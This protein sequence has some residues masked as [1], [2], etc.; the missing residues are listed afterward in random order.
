L[1]VL[2]DNVAPERNEYDDFYN[3]IE[4]KRDPSHFR[5]YK[6]S[7]WIS[8]TENAGLSMECMYTFSKKFHYDT[9]CIMMDLPTNDKAE[10]TTY[11][12][13]AAEPIIHH[14]SMV[15]TEQDVE[16]FEGQSILLAAIKK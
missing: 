10:L 15:F 1:F 12:K 8:M 13:A 6:K 4:K 14:F 2:I 7:E 11:M 16:S 5:A 3:T 9:W